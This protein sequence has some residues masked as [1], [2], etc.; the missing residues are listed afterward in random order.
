LL[1]M[2]GAGNVEYKQLVAETDFAVA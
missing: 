2:L 1:K